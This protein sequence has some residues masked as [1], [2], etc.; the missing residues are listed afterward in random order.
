MSIIKQVAKNS[1]IYGLGDLLT[2]LVGFL[3]IPLYTH[4]LTTAEYGV[5]ELLDLTSYIVGFLLA[6]GIAQAVMRFY[7]E[8]ESEEE[9]NR[10]VSVALLTVWLASAGGLV[11]LQVCAPWFS[12]AVFQ[13]ADYGPHFRI[14]F[15]TL[16]VTISNEIPL[17]YLRI[18]QLAVRFISIS[19][20][21]VSLSLSLNILFIVFYGLG[22][23]GILL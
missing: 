15:A 23:Q 21:R 22:V 4:Y 11:V 1:L 13:S 7:F 12:E 8:Y 6:M 9:R 2:K 10:V 18:R 16:A 14:L 5:L 3:L 17:Q 19:L 20:C